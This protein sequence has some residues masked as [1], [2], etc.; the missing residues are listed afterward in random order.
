M[1]SACAS[2]QTATQ[3]LEQICMT[4][5]NI[6]IYNNELPMHCLYIA[7]D[8]LCTACE[9]LYDTT[10]MVPGGAIYQDYLLVFD[11]NLKIQLQSPKY[12]NPFYKLATTLVSE[13][14]VFARTIIWG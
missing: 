12:R 1:K 5:F 4:F 2:P 9:L 7:Y 6:N 8:Y 11:M 14:S 3:P 10:K 13:C